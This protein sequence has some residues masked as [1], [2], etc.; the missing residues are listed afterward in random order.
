MQSPLLHVAVACI[1]SVSWT[2]ALDTQFWLQ[3]QHLGLTDHKLLTWIFGVMDK[4]KQARVR[5]SLVL[6]L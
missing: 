2:A 1:V 5:F 4:G 3:W 6:V